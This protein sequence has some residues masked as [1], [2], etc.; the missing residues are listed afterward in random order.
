MQEDNLEV[1]NDLA[2]LLATSAEPRLRNPEEALR[3]ARRA[4]EL[5]RYERFGHLATLAA[6]AAAD[7][8]FDEAVKWQARAVELAPSSEAGILRSRLELYGRGQ[9]I[10][11]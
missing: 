10:S 11:Q 5:T 3:L 7:A 4:A 9:D 2:W 1:L 8:Q 6:A